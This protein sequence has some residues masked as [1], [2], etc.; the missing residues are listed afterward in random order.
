VI[1]HLFLDTSANIWRAS[2]SLLKRG[3]LNGV[4]LAGKNVSSIWKLFFVTR[5]AKVPTR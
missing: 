5:F 1:A 2:A 3:K 4:S